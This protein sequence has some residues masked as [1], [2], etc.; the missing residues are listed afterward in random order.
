MQEILAFLAEY[1]YNLKGICFPKIYDAAVNCGEME[2]FMSN[3]ME[4]DTILLE[5]EDAEAVE[6][7]VVAIYEN[8]GKE[9]IALTPADVTDEEESEVFIYRYKEVGE[10]EFE[11]EDIE[12]DAEFDAA[13]DKLEE[14]IAE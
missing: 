13:V 10:D 9:Y 3:E 11:M 7:D 4:K 12:D 14:I 5:F 2:V 8:N 1:Q 6:C